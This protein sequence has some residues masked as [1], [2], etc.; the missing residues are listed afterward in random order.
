M[1]LRITVEGKSYDVEVE[2]LDESPA[3]SL[4]PAASYDDN[5]DVHIPESVLCAPPPHD[6]M[7]DDNI[8][9]SPIAGVVI[10]VTAA[11][12]QRVREG[13]PLVK[14]EAMK[15]ESTIGAPMEGTVQIIRVAAGQSVKANQV[16]LELA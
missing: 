2:F 7:P 14:I 6:G 4:D 5:S 9:R 3:E 10:A 16:L 8:C 13:E 15:M 12:G 11:V 1:K